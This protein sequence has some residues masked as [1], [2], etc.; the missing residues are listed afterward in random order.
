VSADCKHLLKK[1]HNTY[2]NF[3]LVLFF[4]HLFLLAGLH[5]SAD[6]TVFSQAMHIGQRLFKGN[7]VGI[8]G[9]PAHNFASTGYWLP[10]AGPVDG[11][12]ISP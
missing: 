10:G 5:T 6:L 12:C 7:L 9:Q 2:S 11:G 1:K 8:A 4:A 3:S